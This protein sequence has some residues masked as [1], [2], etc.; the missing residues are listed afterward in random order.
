MLVLCWH[1]AEA[2]ASGAL[3]D[4]KMWTSFNAEMTFDSRMTREVV[5]LEKQRLSTLTH[6][7][8]KKTHVFKHQ[9]IWAKHRI[10]FPCRFESQLLQSSATQHKFACQVVRSE[11]FV[12]DRCDQREL[13]EAH[14]ILLLDWPGPVWGVFWQRVGRKH[15]S[16]GGILRVLAIPKFSKFPWS[17]FWCHTSSSIQSTSSIHYKF[18]KLMYHVIQLISYC[19]IYYFSNHFWYLR[20]FRISGSSRYVSWAQNRY[21]SVQFRFRCGKS[22]S[23]VWDLQRFF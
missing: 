18:M 7:A 15:D 23:V 1:K 9:C 22:T 14:A 13:L 20:I 8:P 21:H 11:L 10:V 17:D 16:H 3:E 19:I 6:A 2:S 12:T 5:N 4:W